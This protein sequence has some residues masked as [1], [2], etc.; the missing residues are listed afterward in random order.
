MLGALLTGGRIV[1]RNRFS[2][3][4]FWDEVR[5]HEA[6]W[7]MVVGSVQAILCAAASSDQDRDNPI[8]IAWGAPFTVPRQVFEERFDLVTI[9]GYGSEDAGYVSTTSVTDRGYGTSGKIRDDLYEIRIADEHDDERPV[10]EAGE[11]LIRPREPHAI[12]EGYFGQPELTQ[13]VFRNFWFHTGDLGKVDERGN[14]YF[15]SRLKEVIRRRGENVM[16]H[17]VEEVIQLHEEVDEC[18]AIG[19][20]SPVGEQDVKV[21]VISSPGSELDAQ[22]LKRWCE[23][24]MARFMIPEQVEFV[25]D[26]PRTPTGKPA[27]SVLGRSAS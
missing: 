9:D 3:S 15:L 27:L 5:A 13:S 18:V 23:G 4:R 26:I 17:E 12:M 19:V 14:L 20:D 24:R 6:T 2:A 10:G 22:T 11:I 8:R 25:D 21:Y 16:P 7:F 1:I